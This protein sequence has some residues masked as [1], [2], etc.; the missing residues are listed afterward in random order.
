MSRRLLA[1]LILAALLMAMLPA[2][3]SALDPEQT[4]APGASWFSGDLIQQTG[5]NCST[6][7]LGS[8]YTEVMVSGI[9]SYG[10]VTGIPQVGQ[11]YYTSFLVS[12]PGNPCGPGS[13]SVATDL[14]LPPNTEVDTSAPIRCFGQPRNAST[15]VE[16]T[17]GSWSAFGASGPYCP[18]AAS[19][20]SLQ[21]GALS[22]GFRPLASGQLFE[23]FV[24]VKST[25]PLVGIGASPADGFRWL[26]N[27]TG[28]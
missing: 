9:A 5:E 8:A 1:A 6:A 18:T 10:G 16:L 2:G 14:V 11:R 13:S 23:I 17:G 21:S 15:F 24:P 28:V 19:P 3:A 27:A 22:F 7:I 26:T 4:V 20:S 12:I 25:A